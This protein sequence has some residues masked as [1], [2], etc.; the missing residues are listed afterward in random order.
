[1]KLWAHQKAPWKSYLW[2]V[3]S[4]NSFHELVEKF[5]V[6]GA[7]HARLPQPNV[8]RILQQILRRHKQKQ[9]WRKW[10]CNKKGHKRM[11]ERSTKIHGAHSWDT[12][13]NAQDNLTRLSSGYRCTCASV[14]QGSHC[15]WPT[16]FHDFSMIFP[17]FQSFFQE[18]VVLFVGYVCPFYKT[19]K[20]KWINFLPK[21]KWQ[22]QTNKTFGKNQ[23]FFKGI[24][25]FIFLL[26]EKKWKSNNISLNYH[27]FWE[28]FVSKLYRT[29]FWS[30]PLSWFRIGK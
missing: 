26:V 15:G 28:S 29:K 7:R 9:V 16:K 23:I 12:R 27:L 11:R 22:K 18:F 17:G 14:I 5:L 30:L 4:D 2:S 6:L 24:H 3:P 19:N 8:H 10:V 1:M 25:K 20:V 21:R 13:T